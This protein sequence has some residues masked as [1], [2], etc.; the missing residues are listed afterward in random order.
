MLSTI[1]VFSLLVYGSAAF[2]ASPSDIPIVLQY[3]Y[4]QGSAC[5]PV[6]KYLL[7]NTFCYLGV[8]HFNNV[9]N[10]D[11]KCNCTTENGVP[12]ISAWAVNASAN[13]SYYLYQT[14]VP[15]Q[16]TTNKIGGTVI[17]AAERGCGTPTTANI[18]RGINAQSSDAT[19]PALP[20]FLAH[21]EKILLAPVY[22]LSLVGTWCV[23]YAGVSY[24]LC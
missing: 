4:T 9:E 24:F 13:Y 11:L 5:Q 6:D 19:A 21:F 14:L 17:Y 15:G 10:V 3:T 22:W 18:E 7:I 16:C 12:V 8:G 1:L 20:F 2:T 23:V